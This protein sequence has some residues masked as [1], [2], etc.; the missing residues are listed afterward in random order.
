MS[1]EQLYDRVEE[2]HTANEEATVRKLRMV[3]AEGRREVAPEIRQAALAGSGMGDP[4]LGQALASG[5]EDSSIRS[6]LSSELTR[7]GGGSIR[8]TPSGELVEERGA[9]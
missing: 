1:D 3:R 4:G 8:Q 2:G 7:P 6:T 5:T 9:S